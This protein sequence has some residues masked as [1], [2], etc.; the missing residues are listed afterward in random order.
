MPVAPPR[1]TAGGVTI[2]PVEV[3][4]VAVIAEYASDGAALDGIWLPC[5]EP[6]AV[7]HLWAAWFVREL[8]LGWTLLGGRY[9]GGLAV[10]AL[11]D[12]FVGVLFCFHES[13]DVLEL[14]YGVAPAFRRRGIATAAL[15][16]LA[17]R[18]LSSGFERVDLEIAAHHTVSQA[19]ARG[20]GF[21]FS[22]HR[23]SSLRPPPR[24]TTTTFTPAP[25]NPAA[26]RSFR[27]RGRGAE[28]AYSPAL[29]AP[30]APR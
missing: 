14:S 22:H 10:D 28:G 25:A 16:L 27:E 26:R 7:P 4:D 2:R 24:R 15:T 29:E 17:D 9:G 18:A 30:K 13:P 19:V 1:V 3:D 11:N 6:P 21:T 12:R 8:E 23:P 5:S 20:A